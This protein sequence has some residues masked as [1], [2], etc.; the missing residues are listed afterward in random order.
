VRESRSSTE[1]QRDGELCGARVVH[2]RRVAQRDARRHERQH[3]LVAGTLDLDDLEPVGPRE[4][5]V[6]VDAV[7]V[8]R[9]DEP[10]LPHPRMRVAQVPHERLDTVEI[11]QPSGILLV[12]DGH[13]NRCGAH[14]SPA[15]RG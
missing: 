2:A 5:P 4:H 3:V 7:E 8:R 9:D 12:G 13:D 6:V 11:R 1:G 10:Q 15:I 14:G